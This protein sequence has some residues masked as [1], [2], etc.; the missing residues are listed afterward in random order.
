MKKRLLGIAMVAALSLGY[1]AVAFADSAPSASPSPSG[2]VSGIPTVNRIFP[3]S[4]LGNPQPGPANQSQATTP[5]AMGTVPADLP[6][7]M[8]MVGPSSVLGDPQPAP[9]TA[10][11]TPA[12]SSQV[13]PEARGSVGPL[14]SAPVS[15]G[16][17]ALLTVVTTLQGGIS[18][19]G[20]FAG[21]GYIICVNTSNGNNYDGG[22]QSGLTSALNELPAHSLSW[23]LSAR[24]GSSGLSFGTCL[25]SGLA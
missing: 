20:N 22:V 17:Y 1:P 24:R 25:C 16:Q 6:T 7:I 18:V 19:G 3:L 4:V 10:H 5:V 11:S 14:N 12:S 9:P 8:G 13:Q 23:A 21:G 15:S 2:I